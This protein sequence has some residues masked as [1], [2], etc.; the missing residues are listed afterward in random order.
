MPS[1]TYMVVDPR[2]DLSQTLAVPNAC[3]QCHRVQNNQWAEDAIKRWYGKDRKRGH[4]RY[5]KVLTAA[6][7]G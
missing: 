6:R 3:T 7:E 1:S 5:A 4:Q 2:P